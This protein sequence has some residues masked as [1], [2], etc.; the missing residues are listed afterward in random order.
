MKK[1]L[2][3]KK[4]EKLGFN[5]SAI[6]W[7]LVNTEDKKVTARLKTGKIVT[8]YENGIFKY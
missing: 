6:H 4:K 8:V 2:D 3:K 5:S 1:K 7:D